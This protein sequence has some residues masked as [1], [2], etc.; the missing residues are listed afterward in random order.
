MGNLI[1][2]NQNDSICAI[3]TPQ[4]MGAIALIR[5]SGKNCF[6]VLDSIFSA[7]NKKVQASNAEAY[8][9]IYGSI[10]STQGIIDDVLV[11]VFRTPNSYTGED[12]FEISCHGSVYIQQEILKLLLSKNIRYAQAGE[13]TMRA[14][15][16]GKL[17]LMQAEAVADLIASSN[18][19]AHTL[20]INQ[21]RGGYSALIKNLRSKLVDFASLIELELDF[22]EEDVEFANRDQLQELLT[23]IK[24]Q[25]QRL[26]DSFERG[27]AIKLGIPVAIVGKPNVGKS[28]LL[29]R[30]L[31]ENKAIVSAIPGTTRDAIED[32]INIEG[33]L[34]RFIDTA[35][36][37]AT[38]DEIEQIGIETTWKKIKQASII[39]YVFD[40]R[41]DDLNAIKNKLEE[42]SFE[43][44]NAKII[45]LANKMD[46]F[47]EF[48]AHLN[49]FMEL[50][51]HLISAKRNENIEELKTLLV[52]HFENLP[53]SEGE[54]VSNIRH[55]ESLSNAFVSL[56]NV[57]SAMAAGISGDLISIDLR[58]ALHSL[59]SITGEVY[60]DE[61]L[62]NI[63][64]KFCIGK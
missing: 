27:N 36:L 58:E 48:P 33:V 16:N 22:S 13:F 7:K 49:D 12:S 45:P 59:G 24:L 44:P 19:A 5:V 28:T 55:F 54:I 34:F 62:G 6:D 9:V 37:H 60:T 21:M 50:D 2:I 31:M 11:S 39:L 20:A 26:K 4:G 47:V 35:G 53:Q 14:F 61:L 51:V 64:G 30:L 8:K 25:I 23:N 1:S 52:K 3:A 10:Y 15:F 46:E 18:A 17:N 57:E 42:L 63:F 38:Q 41:H 32:V 56:T 29:N 40:V 43:N